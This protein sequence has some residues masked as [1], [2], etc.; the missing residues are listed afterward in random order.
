MAG[1]L[2]DQVQAA[3]ATVAK[4]VADVTAGDITPAIFDRRIRDAVEVVSACL[5]RMTVREA[6]VARTR[7]LE[8]RDIAWHTAQNR[9]AA[10]E[11]VRPHVSRLSS[12]SRRGL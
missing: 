2:P 7:I 12:I 1:T 4:A 3:L 9:D 11:L 10:R 8:T 6:E 5:D